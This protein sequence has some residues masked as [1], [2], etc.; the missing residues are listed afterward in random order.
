MQATFDGY[1][2]KESFGIV[3]TNGSDTFLAL[4]KRKDSV[5]HNWPEE[6]GIDIDLSNPTYESRDFVLNCALIASS[7]ADFFTKYDA[8]WTQLSSL[9]TH[10]LYHADLDKTFLVFYKSQANVTKLSKIINTTKVGIKFD[11]T[12]SETNP[13][14]NIPAVY[15]VDDL[16]RY[17][18]A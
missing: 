9:G 4:P 5:N 18:T 14:D 16:D 6:Q 10:E 7:R 2:L 12:L 11:L 3:F 15:L 17:L 1:D 8:F 13:D